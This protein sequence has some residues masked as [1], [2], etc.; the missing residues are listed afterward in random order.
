MRMAVAAMN[1]AST[2]RPADGDGDIGKPLHQQTDL[3]VRGGREREQRRGAEAIERNRAVDVRKEIDRH[4]R[5][6]AFLV[7][8]QKDLFQLRQALAAHREDDLVHYVLAQ[9][10][11]Q[12]ADW[13]DLV[14][15]SQ[16]NLAGRAG[17]FGKETAQ[18]HAVFG[19]AFERRRHLQR[20][21]AGPHDHHVVRSGEFTPDHAYHA[22]GG[23][24]E[25]HQQ[26]PR[27]H[28][29]Q[30]HEEAAQV[31]P[32]QVFEDHQAEGAIQTLACSVTQDHS[33]MR[34][35][36]LFVDLQPESDHDP[37][38]QREAH[39]QRSAFG[40]EIKGVLQVQHRTK[41]VGDFKRQE[42][43]DEIG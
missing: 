39:Q 7:A 3:V 34:G 16:G 43:Q 36:E 41:L 26:D 9:N 8:E 27:E 18:P 24:A 6:Q 11:L 20:A 38:Q 2:T 32:D 40:G 35:I 15:G 13:T 37:S 29:E 22:A 25:D 10:G 12:L 1:G 21:V 30:R 4:A 14:S 5:A 23:Q 28:R 19:G 17:P 33:R 31:L 42:G